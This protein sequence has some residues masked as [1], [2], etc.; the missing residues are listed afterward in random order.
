MTSES[1]V[2]RSASF[3]AMGTDIELIGVGVTGDQH[4]AGLQTAQRLAEKWEATFSRF[5]PES[6]LSR[7]NAKGGSP[8]AVSGD[9]F[10]MIERAADAYHR[11]GGR[12]DPTI[13]PALIANGYDRDI[14]LVK[15]GNTANSVPLAGPAPGMDGIELD[16]E[17]LSI[18]LPPGV[19]LDLGGIAKGA[20]VDRVSLALMTWPGGCI[21]AGGD[22][23]VWGEPPD[24]DHWII[25]IEHPLLQN[26]DIATIELRDPRACAVATSAVNRRRWN[27]DSGQRHHLIDPH[28][29]ESA[30]E[31]I[32]SCT[33]FAGSAVEAEVA[34]KSLFVA[35][36]Q[37]APLDL[38][39]AVASLMVDHNGKRFVLKGP[40]S[41]AITIFPA[42]THRQSA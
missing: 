35:A 33:A 27:T 5:R 13:L 23:R 24:G 28:T 10:W 37:N 39:D 34:T 29:G 8:R 4:A 42:D 2:T 19:Q 38:I 25:G 36:A 7:L 11:T 31:T 14:D 26:E 6:E 32:V 30:I 40:A 41:D 17:S 3:R 22:L 18:T 16:P 15:S 9:L 1:R 21:N 12:F 20:Y